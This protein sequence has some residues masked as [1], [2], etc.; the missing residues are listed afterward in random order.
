M[1]EIT[2]IRTQTETVING[3]VRKGIANA[4]ERIADIISLDEQ[5]RSVVT[6]LEELR[7]DMNQA[8]KSIGQL[9]KA[10]KRE[11]AEAAKSAALS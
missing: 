3:L 6:D 5:R 9:M 11:E 2:K 4:P 7:R 10:G 1:L 8:A